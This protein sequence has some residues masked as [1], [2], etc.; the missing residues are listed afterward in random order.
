LQHRQV[1]RLLAFERPPDR[2]VA[3]ALDNVQF[4]SDQSFPEG[5]ARWS[6]RQVWRGSARAC[7]S[8]K[9]TMKTTVDAI[10]YAE[11]LTS[12]GLPSSEMILMKN[13]PRCCR[14]I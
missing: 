10:A 4:V 2:V 8:M 13:D 11:P 7:R 1:R 5:F 14:D 9:P 12:V 3:G 6:L